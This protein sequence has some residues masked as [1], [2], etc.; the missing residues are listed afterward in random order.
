M[1]A[2]TV[3]LLNREL[4]QTLDW[5][6]RL[7]LTAGVVV[8]YAIFW[9]LSTLVGLPAVPKMGGSLLSQ[10][11][12][13]IAI[14]TVVAGLFICVVIGRLIVGDLPVGPDMHFEGGLL[15]ALLGMMAV[16]FRMGPVRY[17]L[18]AM[19]EPQAY[20]LMAVELV[21]I[22]VIVGVCWLLLQWAFLSASTVSD[23]PLK[24]KLS[25]TATHFV[26]MAGCMF[27]LAQ[28]DNTVQALVAVA[29]SAMLASMAAHIAFPVRSSVWYWASPVLVG[30]VGYA[31]AFINPAG[32]SIGFPQGLLGQL[33][34]PTP[35]A[36]ACGG[37]AG[38]IFGF[39]TAYRWHHEQSQ[40]S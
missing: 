18:F 23:E 4:P 26:V 20:L 29:V 11:Q 10:P 16:A 1:P 36:Y 8:C 5:L 13:S 9:W 22:Y 33:A 14:G 28:S 7:R 40:A 17:A 21:L 37:P 6:S 31:I 24:T 3:E 12:P 27:F 2:S 25:A 35:L 30:V 32:L 39:W 19:D 15:V 34:R 38:A